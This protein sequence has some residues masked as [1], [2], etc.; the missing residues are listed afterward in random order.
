MKILVA[1]HN[2]GKLKELA[3][4][5]AG[6]PIQ[7]VTLDDVGITHEIEETGDTF[8]ANARLKAEG[9]A[10]MSNLLTLADDSGLEVDALGGEPGVYS[11]RYGGPGASDD[12]RYRLVL[13]K[14]RDVPPGKRSARFRCVIAVAAPGDGIFT[15]DGVVEGEVA[16][17]PR[18]SHGFGYDPIFWMAE[19]GATLA[20]L[21]PEIKNQVSHRARAVQAV[22]PRLEALR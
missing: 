16:F 10:E 17:E 9:Y 13:E 6:L 18:G 11:A 2:P 3:E 8:E 21:G 5:L 15:A 19:Y 14:M 22:R 4:L 12:D 1:S 20:E 7:W